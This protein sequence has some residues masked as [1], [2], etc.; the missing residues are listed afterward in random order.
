MW[1][2]LCPRRKHHTNKL[3]GERLASP[4][5]ARKRSDVTRGHMWATMMVAYTCIIVVSIA[6]VPSN[7]MTYKI[8]FEDYRG[9]LVKTCNVNAFT[10]GQ[11]IRISNQTEGL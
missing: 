4:V 5:R 10:K 3:V 6:I 11:K 2:I 7:D 9:S 1:V 8:K